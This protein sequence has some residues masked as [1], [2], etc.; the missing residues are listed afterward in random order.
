LIFLGRKTLFK[1]GFWNVLL[2]HI[3]VSP[4]D[5][6][7]SADISAIR[8]ALSFL[9]NG[10]GVTIF[11]E[12]TRSLDGNFG[13]A[14]PGIGFLACKTQVPVIPVRLW[15]TYEILKKYRTFP[16]IRRSARIVIGE[17][18]L[19]EQY[20]RFRGEKERY[21]LTANGILDAVKNLTLPA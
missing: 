3:N 17:P 4:V 9:K 14:Q 10:F 7:N 13:A 6:E 20:D 18:L 5:K 2:S 11:P 12:G 15:G 21:Y 8:K 19:P 16:D 1:P